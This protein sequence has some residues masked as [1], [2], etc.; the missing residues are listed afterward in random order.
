MAHE[1]WQ[2]LP[3][4]NTNLERKRKYHKL[5]GPNKHNRVL[6]LAPVG[7]QCLIDLKNTDIVVAG[8]STS[9]NAVDKFYDTLSL[10]NY[11]KATSTAIYHG[12]MKRN[13]YDMSAIPGAT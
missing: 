9:R 4:E 7:N 1:V 13:L 10:N 8:I 6:F 11:S 2:N 5:S 3:C 12:K